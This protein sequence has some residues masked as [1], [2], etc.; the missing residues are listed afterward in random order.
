MFDTYIKNKNCYPIEEAISVIEISKQKPFWRGVIVE[1]SQEKMSAVFVDTQTGK[2]S[3]V[4][5]DIDGKVCFLQNGTNFQTIN[6]NS[7]EL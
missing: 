2:W 4:S 6:Q 3:R 1:N 5:I 7:I